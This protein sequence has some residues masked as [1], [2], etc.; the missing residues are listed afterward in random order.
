MR[1]RSRIALP[2]TRAVQ[3]PA[4][5]AE[6]A[7]AVQVE[8]KKLTHKSSDGLELTADY[9]KARF[10]RERP[11]VVACHMAGSS[12]AEYADIAAELTKAGFFVLAVDLRSGGEHGGV[13]NETAER[14][15]KAGKPVGYADAYADLV[16]AV[17]W[18]RELHPR[19][20]IALFGSSYSA[21]LAIAYAGRVPD[22]VDAVC[23]FSPGKY[24]EGWN[25]ALEARKVVVP[26]YV[27]CGNGP[28]EQRHA[29]PIFNALPK[30][31]RS[32]FFPPDYIP[33]AH[34]A[35]TL[36]PE[37]PAYRNRQWEPVWK[38]LRVLAG[39]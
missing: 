17:A 21:A 29:R 9:Y 36:M 33:A 34:G 11:I 16:A 27:T 6:P 10:P 1:A 25:L 32:S 2:S 20:K 18:A 14:A 39:D 37:D 12:R 7:E 31:V 8:V 13:K 35:P 4:P 3:D 5:P 26:T 38:V 19:S 24:I 30:D 23:A 28:E 15:Q 22:G